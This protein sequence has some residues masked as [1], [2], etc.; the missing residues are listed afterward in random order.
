MARI[1][2]IVANDFEDSEFR[3]PYDTVRKAGHEAVIIGVEAGK[4]LK[5]KKGK[6]SIKAEK[7]VTTAAR[8]AEREA[9]AEA[10]K[11]HREEHQKTAPPKKPRRTSR[12][13]RSDAE[14]GGGAG[15]QP[16]GS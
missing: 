1:A 14:V 10:E 12:T 15:P 8:E 4:Q 6:E 3:V 5:G 16:A 9:E 7:A 11:V 13:R 2:F